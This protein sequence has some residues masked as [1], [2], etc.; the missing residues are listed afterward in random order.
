MTHYSEHEKLK[1]IKEQKELIE[2]FLNRL[3]HGEQVELLEPLRAGWEDEEH[4]FHPLGDIADEYTMEPVREPVTDKLCRQI[5][6]TFF[7]ID[8]DALQKE[9]EAMF[10]ELQ[11]QAA[12]RNERNG[13]AGQGAPR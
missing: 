6:G 9:K 7:G 13:L 2:R 10:E 4:G 1:S 11:S 12:D 8:P 3:R 5:I